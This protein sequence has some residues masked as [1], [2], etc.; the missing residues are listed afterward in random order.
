VVEQELIDHRDVLI[1]LFVVW[2]MT[3][4]F[5]PDELRSGNGVG[6]CPGDVG[7]HVQIE[8][9]LDHKRWEVEVRHLRSKVDLAT[10]FETAS[11]VAEAEPRSGAFARYRSESSWE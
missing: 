8:A 11:P 3:A 7:G 1:G 10:A 5:E 2:Q 4:F 6:H 9:A